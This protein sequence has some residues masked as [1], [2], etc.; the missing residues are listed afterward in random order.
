M[1]LI[2]LLRCYLYSPYRF[3]KAFSFFA[4]CRK[5]RPHKIYFSQGD[6]EHSS[7]PILVSKLLGIDSVSYLPLFYDKHSVSARYGL[8]RDFL[9]LFP[10]FRASSYITVDSYQSQLCL[11]RFNIKPRVLYNYVEPIQINLKQQIDYS[12]SSKVLSISIPA[13]VSFKHKGQDILLSYISE[14]AAPLSRIARF[15]FYGEGSDSSHLSYLISKNH[16]SDFVFYHGHGSTQDIYNHSCI[17][18]PSLFEGHLSF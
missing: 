2:A 13:R 11:N 4:F 6:I 17:L 12:S 14:F 3:R 9:I 7:I 18:L 16:L 15:H 5:Y 8:I 1:A 10:F